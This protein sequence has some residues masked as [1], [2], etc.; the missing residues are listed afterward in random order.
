[1]MNR[2]I[3]HIKGHLLWPFLQDVILVSGVPRMIH[4]LGLTFKPQ[5]QD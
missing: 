5:Q 1:M 4:T 3:I 2:L